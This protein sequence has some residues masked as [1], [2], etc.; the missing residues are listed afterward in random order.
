[1][2]LAL[3]IALT[4]LPAASLESGTQLQFKGRFVAEKGDPVITEKSFTFSCLVDNASREGAVV[5]WTLEEQGRGKWSWLDQ[6]G[7]LEVNGKWQVNSAQLPTL[8]YQRPSGTSIVPVMLPMFVANQ[9]LSNKAEWTQDRMDYKVIG[10]SRVAGQQGWKIDIRNVY[11]HQRTLVIDKESPIV[12]ASTSTVFIGQGE[13]HE[14][15]FELVK[16]TQLTQ[17]QLVASRRGFDA[18]LQLRSQLNHQPRKRD[19]QWNPAR[20]ATLRKELPA[21][22]DRVT[23]EPLLTIA[24]L[25]RLDA[26]RQQNRS[27][28][29]NFVRKKLVGQAAPHPRITEIDGTKFDWKKTKGKVTVLHFWDYRDRP[30]EEPYGQVAYVDFLYRKRKDENVVVFG[31]AVNQLLDDPATHRRGVQSAKKLKSF[32]NLS[33]PVLVDGGEA[34]KAFGDPRVTGAKL[35]VVVVID[36]AGKVV[37]YHVGFYKF[38]RDRGLAELD[39]AVIQAAKTGS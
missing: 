25:A 12:L 20:L 11:G 15:T 34:I 27:G 36:A 22:L 37:H 5:Y 29:I 6:F 33:Y 21:T 32:M 18:L 3:V 24:Q 35:P 38:D 8:F 2:H 39:E 30:L 23:S 9:P 10:D 16:R 1:M 31:V 28:A 19:F 7:K 17:S 13:E 14:L 4:T 26:K